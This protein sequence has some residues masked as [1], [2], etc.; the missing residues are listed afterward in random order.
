MSPK[1][2]APSLFARS[3]CKKCT[4]K[5]ALQGHKWIQDI[6]RPPLPDDNISE[7]RTLWN[8]I[9]EDGIMLQLDVLDSITWKTSPSGI[10]SAAAAYR[11]QFVDRIEPDYANMF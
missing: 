8:L 7:F 11:L 5:E 1:T 6:P 9:S 3:R 2:I 10:Y 4:V